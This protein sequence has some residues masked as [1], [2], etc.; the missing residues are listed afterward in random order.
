M[1]RPGMLVM[2]ASLTVPWISGAVAGERVEAPTTATV[3]PQAASQATIGLPLIEED[4][5]TP[6]AQ[7]AFAVIKGGHWR[8][9]GYVYSLVHPATQSAGVGNANIVV[10]HRLLS[11][12]WKLKVRLAAISPRPGRDGFSVIFGFR[13]AKD[14]FYA[15]FSKATL[16]GTNGVFE[17]TGKSRSELTS[18]AGRASRFVPRRN[19]DIV[20]IKFGT[21]VR[22]EEDGSTLAVF[23]NRSLRRAARVG[24][25]SQGSQVTARDLAVLTVTPIGQPTPTPGGSKGALTPLVP[26]SPRRP[27]PS[28]TPTAPSPTPTVPPAGSADLASFFGPDFKPGAA[29]CTFSDQLASIADSVL[30]VTYPPGSTAPSMGPP[31]GGAQLCEPFS[32]GPQTSATLTYQVRFPVGFQFVKGGKL[33]GLYGG[34]EPFSGGGHNADGWSLRLMWRADGAGEIYA[35][36]AG[37]SGYGEDLGRGDFTWPADGAWHTVSEAVTLNTPGA[38][39]GSAV[40]SLDGKVVIDSTGLDITDT[41]TPISGLFFSTF[42]GG[43]DPSWAPTADMHLDFANFSAS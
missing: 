25:G 30:T 15:N 22:V 34:V 40:L 17:V 23:A 4:F 16:A 9:G 38:T 7:Q 36:I 29:F 2:L 35:Y 42:Y 26:S 11:E 10:T 3:I 5:A 12:N 6:A 37:V 39:N 43:H 24:L 20:L 1:I 13:S 31:F 18:F 41:A 21:S 8:A 19:Y 33:P 27:T 28:P 32:S 14:Y